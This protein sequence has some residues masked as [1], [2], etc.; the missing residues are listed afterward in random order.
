MEKNYGA[1]L[2]YPHHDFDVVIDYDV[3]KYMKVGD[4]L[5]PFKMNHSNPEEKD[6]KKLKWM[7]E[8]NAP[9]VTEIQDE[10]GFLKPDFIETIMHE[11]KITMKVV[12]VCWDYDELEIWAIFIDT[13]VNENDLLKFG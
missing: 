12:N 4:H 8:E 6:W 7:V 9:W 1:R 11:E 5:E 13:T 3:A 10:A 2:R